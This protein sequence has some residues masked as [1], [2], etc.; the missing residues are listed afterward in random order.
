[1]EKEI[2]ETSSSSTDQR[3]QRKKGKDETKMQRTI[4]QR[5]EEWN[6]EGTW[7]EKAS[8]TNG[9]AQRTTDSKELECLKAVLKE[10]SVGKG[11]MHERTTE[12]RFI[13]C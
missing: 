2:E 12:L 8:I 3:K 5:K 1:M 10:A 7:K 9:L 13:G 4:Q 11:V 6:D